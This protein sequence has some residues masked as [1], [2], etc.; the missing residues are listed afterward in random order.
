MPTVYVLRILEP[1]TA[2]G[3]G[4]LN[5][6]LSRAIQKDF[7][8]SRILYLS[9]FISVIFL[10]HYIRNALNNRVRKNGFGLLLNHSCHIARNLSDQDE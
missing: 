2:P 3:I 7:L 1:L 10:M 4:H 5:L 8:S 9:D 6:I